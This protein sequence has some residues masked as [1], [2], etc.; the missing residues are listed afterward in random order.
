MRKRLMI[1]GIL[2]CVQVGAPVL[3][4]QDLTVTSVMKAS[5]T[6]SGQTIEYPKTEKAEITALMIVLQPGKE[7]GPHLHP[8]PTYVH[9]LEGTLTVEAEDGS[10]QTFEAGKGFLESVNVSHNGKNLGDMPVKFLVVFVGERGQ[11]N[12]VRPQKK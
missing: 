5:T 10:R 3:A 4:E 6:I 9:V 7:S 2:V 12:V 8:M 11:P 1:L